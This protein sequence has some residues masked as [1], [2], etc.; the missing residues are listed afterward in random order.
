MLGTVTLP[1]LAKCLAVL[2]F[3]L[4]AVCVWYAGLCISIHPCVG[5]RTCAPQVDVESLSQLFFHCANLSGF[6]QYS[7]AFIDT[8]SLS[9]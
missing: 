5:A 3:S 8:A 7:P 9:N 6:A 4:H 1:V 2:A